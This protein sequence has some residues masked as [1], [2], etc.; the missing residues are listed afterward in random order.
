MIKSDDGILN[1]LEKYT[2]NKSIFNHAGQT[3]MNAVI[4]GNLLCLKEGEPMPDGMEPPPPEITPLHLAGWVGNVE[5]ARALLGT[6]QVHIDLRDKYGNTALHYASLRG[7]T[8][9]IKVCTSEFNAN[10]MVPNNANELVMEV[11]QHGRLSLA[12]DE[13]WDKYDALKMAR[14]A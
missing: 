1:V 10:V 7:H 5:A 9:F 14:E 12:P 2:P 3:P 4:T 13:N 11:T 8:E 6:G